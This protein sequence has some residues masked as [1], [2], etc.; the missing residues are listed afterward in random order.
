MRLLPGSESRGTARLL[1]LAAPEGHVQRRRFLRITAELVAK[2]GY[3]DV[4]V[5]LISDRA[6]VSTRTF[7]RQFSS[8]QQCFIEFFDAAIEDGRAQVSAALAANP[9]ATWPEQVAVA[10]RRLF[11]FLLAD[12]VTARAC[13]VEAPS[14]GRPINDR[15]RQAI[16]SFS[17]LIR[18]GRQFAEHPDTLP[19]SLEDTLAAGLLWSVH[20][21]ILDAELD[22]LTA[23]LP[24]AV[25]F[26]L[27]PYLGEAE[28][29][30]WAR[31]A[32]S[33]TSAAVSSTP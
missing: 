12:P 21:R 29:A 1:P 20:E 13:I 28:A 4:T 25:E 9:S 32:Q 8:K 22:R 26:V 19:S 11:E 31:W 18:Q 27:R 15:Y 14:V 3:A 10:L 5:E 24:E 7:Y 16:R 2:R 23:L 6:G 17:P 30:R 33:P